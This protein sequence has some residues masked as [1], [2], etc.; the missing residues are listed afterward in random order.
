MLWSLS[1]ATIA[2]CGGIGERFQDALRVVAGGGGIC[3]K[4]GVCSGR[5]YIF[6]PENALTVFEVSGFFH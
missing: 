4:R 1:S 3:R 6:F 2:L 5:G